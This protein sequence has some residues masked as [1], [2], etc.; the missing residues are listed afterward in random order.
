[1]ASLT[2]QMVSPLVPKY[3]TSLATHSA[4]TTVEV[5]SWRTF[6]MTSLELDEENNT[7]GRL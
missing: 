6:G 7:G 4:A 1:M 3:S 2:L 5:F